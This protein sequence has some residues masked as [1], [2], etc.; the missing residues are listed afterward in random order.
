MRNS[1]QTKTIQRLYL[2]V[3]PYVEKHCGPGSLTEKR[4]AQLCW[5]AA[6]AMRKAKIQQRLRPP[7]ADR[8]D[9]IERRIG[10]LEAKYKADRREGSR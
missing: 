9:Q 4:F 6:A 2:K 3:R 10:R 1:Y 5:E 7:L 8:L